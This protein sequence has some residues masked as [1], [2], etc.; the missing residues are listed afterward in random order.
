ME[1]YYGRCTVPDKDNKRIRKT[2]YFSLIIVSKPFYKSYFNLCKPNHL[3]CAPPNFT[4]EIITIFHFDMGYIVTPLMDLTLKMFYR[5]KT[6][7]NPLHKFLLSLTVK[8][9][10]KHHL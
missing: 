7:I 10:S 9:T 5:F 6:L 1:H 4:P 8:I 2:Y 3:S